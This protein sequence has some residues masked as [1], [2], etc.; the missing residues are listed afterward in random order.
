MDNNIIMMEIS[1]LNLN[2]NRTEGKIRILRSKLLYM[3]GNNPILLTGLSYP[4]TKDPDPDN[5]MT[6]K[7]I[8]HPSFIIP[9]KE[10]L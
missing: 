8:C 5:L 1:S 7:V 2:I 10:Y 9:E 3:N 6:E 4:L